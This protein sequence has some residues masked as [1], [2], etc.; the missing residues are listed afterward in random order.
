MPTDKPT[1]P[2][3]VLEML[4]MHCGVPVETKLNAAPNPNEWGDRN[5]AFV[6]LAFR[7]NVVYRMK[8][9]RDEPSESTSGT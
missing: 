1:I 7:P 3:K 5:E 8:R 6:G 4:H 2:R 9:S